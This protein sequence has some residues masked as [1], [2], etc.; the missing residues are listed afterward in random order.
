MA[1]V[2]LSSTYIVP[3]GQTQQ[4]QVWKWNGKDTAAKRHEIRCV[5]PQ[6]Q[7]LG[8][9][10]KDSVFWAVWDRISDFSVSLNSFCLPAW[11]IRFLIS[12]TKNSIEMLSVFENL[13]KVDLH[14]HT[15]GLSLNCGGEKL[16]LSAAKSF[17]FDVDWY[18]C[19]SCT[20][21]LSVQ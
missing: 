4:N 17:N 21:A 1:Y 9:A 13:R 14:L 7:F 10:C 19:D 15:G 2:S 6:K 8:V 16:R 20:E 11:W 12:L 5:L 3:Y 18:C